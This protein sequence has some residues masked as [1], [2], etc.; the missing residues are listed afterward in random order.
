MGAQVLESFLERAA[1]VA[2]VVHEVNIVRGELELTLVCNKSSVMTMSDRNDP[3]NA[4]NLRVFP[5]F[6]N[7]TMSVV[8]LL[9]GLNVLQGPSS[10]LALSMRTT[11][12]GSGG[13]FLRS[14]SSFFF[15]FAIATFRFLMRVPYKDGKKN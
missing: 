8:L 1:A 10:L 3:F 12:R 4:F 11:F 14:L 7:I 2:E 9:P 6:P 15:L 13:G 5:V